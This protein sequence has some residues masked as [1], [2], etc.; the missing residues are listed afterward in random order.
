MPEGRAVTEA[1]A[2]LFTDLYEMTM[3][4]AYWLLGMREEAVFSLYS[5]RLP[6]RRNFLLACGLDDALH[7]LETLRFS[8]DALAYLATLPHFRPD[9]L[10]WLE[11][12]RFSGAVYAVPEGTPL[13]GEEPLLEV[14]API[15]EAQLAETYLMNQVQLQTV[16]ASKAVR[17]VRAARGRRVVDFGLRRT[18]GTDAGLKAARAYYIAG[19]DATS[20]LLAGELYGIPV[21]GTMAHSFV[22]AFDRE[23]DAFRAFA[24]IYPGTTL[25]VDTYDTIEGVRRV[26]EVVRELGPEYR[27]NAVRLNSGDVAAL[28]LRA[29]EILDAAG[30]TE[31]EIF[32]SGGLDE[33]EIARLVS[34]GAP[35]DAFGVG[36]AL[37]VSKDAPALDIAYKLT[38]YAGQGRTKL[39]AGKRILPGRKQIFRVEEGGRGVRD[40]LARHDETHPGRPLLRQVMA[41]GRRL[42]SGEEDL[43]AA[44]ARARTEIAL[45]PERVQENDLADPPY[46]VEVS[47]ALEAE[48]AAATQRYGR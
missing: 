25:L 5:R 4:Q 36:T 48:L 3:I 31:V 27:V 37:A 7:Y 46:P 45:L 41:G 19:I 1:N 9:F 40:I 24:R 43:A 30:L 16:L 10:A 26:V 47:P 14:V 22:Q 11:E 39:S 23:V 42:A 6:A 44:R 29:R 13:F 2:A 34:C 20:N 8:P 21:A 35:I 15:A 32:A 33:D 28:A 18:Q 17:V 38:S 12:F